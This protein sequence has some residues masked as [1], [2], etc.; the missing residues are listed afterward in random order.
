MVGMARDRSRTPAAVRITTAGQSRQADT[1]ARQRRYLISMGIRTLCFIGAVVAGMLQINWLWP[2]LI[3]AAV[4]LPYVAVVMA[5]AQ[6]NRS[7]DADLLDP[8][9]SHRA[10]GPKGDE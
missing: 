10:L 4:V 8:G 5:N 9:V 6:D 2:T 3:V 1:M 7:D